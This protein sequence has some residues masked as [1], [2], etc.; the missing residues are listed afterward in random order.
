MRW[1]CPP[2]D[3]MKL[4]KDASFPPLL[5]DAQQEADPVSGCLKSSFCLDCFGKVQVN[6]A[7]LIPEKKN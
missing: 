3:R 7:R 1:F 4:D 6:F 2:D 5:C